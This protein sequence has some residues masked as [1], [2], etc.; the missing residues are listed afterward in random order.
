MRNSLAMTLCAALLAS[1]SFIGC[2]GGDDNPVYFPISPVNTGITI[3]QEDMAKTDSVLV[4]E[5]NTALANG[6]YKTAVDKFRSAY[7]KNPSDANKIY[8][9]LTELAML[10]VDET[11]VDIVRNKIGMTSY[12]A[13]MNALLNSAW[14]KDKNQ[15]ILGSGWT[16]TY[17]RYERAPFFKAI[18]DDNGSLIRVSGTRTKTWSAEARFLLGAW[19]NGEWRVLTTFEVLTNMI[20][21]ANGPYLVPRDSTKD[22]SV[23]AAYRYSQIYPATQDVNGYYIRVSGTPTN[24]W[25]TETRYLSYIL[26]NGEWTSSSSDGVI[27]YL[28]NVTP[29]TNGPYLVFRDETKDASV[30]ANYNYNVNMF[31]YDYKVVPGDPITLPE[32]AVPS[33]VTSIDSYK[34]TLIGSTLSFDTWGYLLYANIIANNESGFNDIIDKLLAVVHKKSETIKSIVDTIGVGTATLEPSFIA[35]LNLKEFFGDDGFTISK[36]EMNVLVSALE[37]IDAVLNF[38]AS[39]DLSGNLK[40]AETDSAAKQN[41]L[42]TIRNCVTSKTLASRDPTKMAAAKLLLSDALGRA[43]SSYNSIKTSTTYP[44]VIKDNI[45][46]Y[47]DFFYDGAVKAKAAIESGSVFYIPKTMEGSAFPTDLSS[48]A[49]GIDMGKIF[50]PGYFTNYF[51]RSA[52]LSTIKFYYKRIEK[53]VTMTTSPTFSMNQTETASEL[54]E[55][56]DI[57]AFFNTTISDAGFTYNTTSSTTTTTKISYHVGLLANQGVLSAALPNGIE[58]AT[59]KIKFMDF[60]HIN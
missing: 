25:G 24:T 6:E 45:A 51:E 28:T 14:A 44:Q 13:E 54:T 34:S 20:P 27:Q 5:A 16:K 39:Y 4:N 42:K 31:I 56:T 22:A 53:T 37:G 15:T 9:A 10:S 29:D 47:G 50:T 58:N 43:I 12:P 21:D 57:D 60:I 49:F 19:E 2:S 40:A 38:V 11:V 30:S 8:Y 36:T 17:P 55:I 48:A 26:V 1:F 7:A 18:Q 35:S 59:E 3:P 52:D 23:S 33:W 41:T 32:L 46:K